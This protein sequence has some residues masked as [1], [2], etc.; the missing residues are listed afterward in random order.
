M[1]FL[2]HRNSLW[3]ILISNDVGYL[4]MKMGALI[5]SQA[6]HL[7][8]DGEP[9]EAEEILPPSG[10]GED[11]ECSASLASDVAADEQEDPEGA[12]EQPT[13]GGGSWRCPRVSPAR[14]FEKRHGRTLP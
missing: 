9:P 10:V 11:Q 8:R 7:S 6:A 1:T 12:E 3:G 14:R 13:E 4:A 5:C 2:V